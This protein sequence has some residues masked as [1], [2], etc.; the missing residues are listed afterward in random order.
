MK[1]TLDKKAWNRRREIKKVLDAF[2]EAMRNEYDTVVDSRV[3]DLMELFETGREKAELAGLKK[4]KFFVTDD[5]KELLL[6]GLGTRGGESE[7][8][9]YLCF[10]TE[11]M[12]GFTYGILLSVRWELEG[13]VEG[14]IPIRPTLIRIDENGNAEWFD[15]SACEW[16]ADW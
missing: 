11:P 1:E 2:V 15:E 10:E 3:K 7:N 16:D 9:D 5:A 12:D 14:T 8:E 4:P 13:V 6:A